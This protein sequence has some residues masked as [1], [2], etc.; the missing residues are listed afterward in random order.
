MTHT[1]AQISKRSVLAIAILFAV[2]SI[3]IGRSTAQGV[4]TYTFSTASGFALDPLPGS[5]SMLIGP[6]QD[7][8]SSSVTSIGFTFEFDGSYYSNFSANSNGLVSLGT[9]AVSTSGLNQLSN[10]SINPKLAPYWD[11]LTTGT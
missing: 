7:D 11:D 9:T 8:V 4:S 10:A 2:L 6:G 5:F 3:S 1:H